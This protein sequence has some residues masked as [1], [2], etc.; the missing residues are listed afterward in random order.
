MNIATALEEKFRG[1]ASGQM[2]NTSTISVMAVIISLL[3]S[4]TKILKRMKSDSQLYPLTY[5]WYAALV[6]IVQ[7]LT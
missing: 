7:S 5:A 6:G 4:R 3:D 1:A 2:Q